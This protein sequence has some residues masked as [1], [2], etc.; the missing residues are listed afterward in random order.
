MASIGVDIDEVLSQT[1]QAFLDFYNAKYDS[2]Y[3]LSQVNVYSFQKVFGINA[4]EE[5]RLHAEFFTTKFSTDLK[6]VHGSVEGVNELS[7]T[8]KLFAISSRPKWQQQQTVKWLN[9][10]YGNNFDQIKLTDSHF[11]KTSTKS[12][13]CIDLNLDYFIEDAIIYAEDCAAVCK[14]VFLLNRPWNN[15]KVSNNNIIRVSS[16]AEIVKAINS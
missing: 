5:K 12:S 7:K 14:K 9:L 10:H 4:E 11:D 15:E 3:S 8:H 1:F 2:N 6:T 13:V 16:W